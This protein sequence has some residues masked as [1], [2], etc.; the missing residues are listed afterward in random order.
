MLFRSAHND[1]G[2]ALL[3]LKRTA[4]AIAEYQE[5]LRIAPQVAEIHVNLGVA[6]YRG[7]RAAEAA[8]QFAEALRINPDNVQARRGLEMARRAVT[9]PD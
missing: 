2:N 5:A 8:G 6:L 3:G 1:L 7:G 9:R 4:E